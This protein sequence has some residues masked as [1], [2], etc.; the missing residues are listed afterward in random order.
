MGGLVLDPGRWGLGLVFPLTFLGLLVPLLTRGV[1]GAVAL[2]SGIVVVTTTA[3]LPGKMNL[4]LATL[5]A[6][7]VGVILERRWKPSR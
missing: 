4:F 1:T 7:G 2:V 5:M 3:W 6:S